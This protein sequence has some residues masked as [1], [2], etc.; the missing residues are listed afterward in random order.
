M[1]YRHSFT[2]Q[3]PLDVVR[4]FHTLSSS[5]TAITP[6]PIIVQIIQ[7]PECLTEGDEMEFTMWI[8]GL[9]L[10]WRAR[11]ENVSAQGFIDRQIQGPFDAWVHNHTFINIDEKSTEV[12]DELQIN[13]SKNVFWGLVGAGM[14]LS[15]PILF[16]YR[17]WKTQRLL[18]Q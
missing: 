12:R 5:L 18:H 10:R 6:P 1:K 3:A 8:L 7:A 4:E 16:A 11:I 17:G 14:C 2:T 9:P 15:L 13:L